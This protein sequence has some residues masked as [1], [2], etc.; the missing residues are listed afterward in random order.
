MWT[1]AT[2]CLTSVIPDVSMLPVHIYASPC[3]C[4]FKTVHVLLLV[5]NWELLVS[6]FSG[7]IPP[8]PMKDTWSIKKSTKTCYKSK[9]KK[10]AAPFKC[11]TRV[12]THSNLPCNPLINP[13]RYLSAAETLPGT[14]PLTTT[15]PLNLIFEWIDT[16]LITVCTMKC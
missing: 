4:I 14:L 8:S 13:E 7:N 11:E 1:S 2:E 12:A 5:Q 3:W 16:S 6:N 9:H 15:P 10:R